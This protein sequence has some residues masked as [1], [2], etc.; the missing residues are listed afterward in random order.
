MTK[1]QATVT[2]LIAALSFGGGLLMRPAPIVDNRDATAWASYYNELNEDYWIL[3]HEYMRILQ[4]IQSPAPYIC[5]ESE[6]IPYPYQ[7][8]VIK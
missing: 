8:L 3:H 4:K 1:K 5:T 7:P 2:A 6:P